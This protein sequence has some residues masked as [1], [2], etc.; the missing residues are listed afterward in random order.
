MHSCGH[1][2]RSVKQVPPTS[3]WPSYSAKSWPVATNLLGA[4]A[5]AVWRIDEQGTLQRLSSEGLSR[6][7]VE[8][9]AN[10][11]VGEGV[12]GLVALS[13]HPLA[14]ADVASDS[15][16]PAPALGA[17]R[18]PLLL[19]GAA[20]PPGPAGGGLEHLSARRSRVHAGRNRTAGQ[21]LGPRRHGYRECRAVR[22]D[23][24]GGGGSELAS[25][26]SCRTSSSTPRMAFSPWIASGGSCCS[27][28]A[29]NASRAGRRPRSWGAWCSRSCQARL[30][31]TVALLMPIPSPVPSIPL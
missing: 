5:A 27:A 26:S 29:A 17:G 25:G 20:A 14:V 30:W 1:S 19:G 9:V 24:A 31:R 10:L 22:A 3:R 16:A 13:A 18:H 6:E 11:E 23:R 2:W 21:F 4:S 12:T 7:Y 8:A 28:P 15:R